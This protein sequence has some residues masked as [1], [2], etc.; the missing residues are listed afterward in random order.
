VAVEEGRS[1]G[2]RIQDLLTLAREDVEAFPL[3]LGSVNLQRLLQGLVEKTRALCGEG[4]V[5]VKTSFLPDI[6]Q[7]TGDA[8]RLEQVFRNLL[9]N[10]RRALFQGGTIEI[11]VIPPG[12]GMLAVEV[13]DDGPGIPPEDLDTLFERFQRGAGTR[14]GG[15]G[16]G[17][18]IVKRIVE[19]HGGRCEVESQPGEGSCFR[20]L[21]PCEDLGEGL[22]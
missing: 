19:R 18:A 21:L 1:L 2:E 3:E 22:D 9:E 16:L 14:E 15:T 11:R 6:H 13:R 10:A 5:Q 20:V 12:Q 17:L 7:V 8:S 4:G